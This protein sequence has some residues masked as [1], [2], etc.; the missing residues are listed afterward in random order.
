MVT[1]ALSNTE[2]ND[3]RSKARVIFSAIALRY[4]VGLNSGWIGP[5]IPVISTQ[6]SMT[7]VQCGLIV[8]LSFLGCILIVPFNQILLSRFGERQCLKYSALLIG[9]GFSVMALSSSAELLWGGSF[10]A[11]LGFGINTVAGAVAVLKFGDGQPNVLLNR[12]L[13][14][15]GAGALTGPL[16]AWGATSLPGSYHGVYFLG[17]LIAAGIFFALATT[18]DISSKREEQESSTVPSPTALKDVTMWLFA[19]M[20]FVY[21][22]MEAGAMTWLYTHL[23][24]GVG[25]ER[26]HAALGMSL[27]WAGLSLGRYLGAV[28]GKRVSAKKITVGAMFTAMASISIL[29][30][31]PNLWLASLLVVGVMGIGFGP[32]FPNMLACATVRKPSSTATITTVMFT[33]AC[34][35]GIVF[36]WLAGG[37]LET[38]GIRSA[39]TTFVI[40][41][42]V[43]ILMF[44]LIEGASARRVKDGSKS[45]T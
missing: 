39:M 29:V 41:N 40:S 31:V 35:G 15:F 32:I 26:A 14:F 4:L 24:E 17:A 20:V 10:I 27:L 25:I 42:A 11:G 5:L 12:L 18:E 3:E 21:A 37:I 8:S 44:L 30:F 28:L 34:T 43:L 22:G 9:I 36:P 38:A 23:D 13:V 1:S 2:P 6:Q 19:A 33:S 7:L 45:I 16:L